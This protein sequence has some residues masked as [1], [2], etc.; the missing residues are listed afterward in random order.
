MVRPTTARIATPSTRASASAP[1]SNMSSATPRNTGANAAC[2]T[3]ERGALQRYA[4]CRPVVV[5]TTEVR[6]P[7]RAIARFCGFFPAA[8]TPASLQL[9]PLGFASQ[10]VRVACEYAFAELGGER[11]EFCLEPESLA[12]C[13]P[14]GGC[15][16]EASLRKQGKSRRRAA[17]P[18]LSPAPH[19]ID[20][21]RSSIALR[22]PLS[23][24]FDWDPTVANGSI[25]GTAFEPLDPLSDTSASGSGPERRAGL[26]GSDGVASPCTFTTGSMLSAGLLLTRSQEDRRPCE[27]GGLRRTSPLRREGEL[28]VLGRAACSTRSRHSSAR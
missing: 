8:T 6:V 17:R 16:E 25:S 21:A 13:R 28:G 14:H 4:N 27:T 18:C 23:Y 11:M 1:K 24:R 7:K 10:A 19:P 26:A 20:R 3:G 2:Q 9:N 5:R 15:V 22:G 12:S